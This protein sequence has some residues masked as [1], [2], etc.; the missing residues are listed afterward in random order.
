MARKRFDRLR[1][2]K[3]LTPALAAY[4]AWEDARGTRPRKPRAASSKPGGY[5]RRQVLPFG[6]EGVDLIRVRASERAINAIG[7]IIANRG[8]E[9]AA[10]AITLGNFNPAK[11][12]IFIG[13]G[14]ATS[15]ISEITRLSYE[16]KTGNS[17][18]APFGGQSATEKEFEAQQ[19]I[20]T[21]VF[22]TP[23]R[24]VS[25]TPERMYLYA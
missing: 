9:A 18:T 7:S 2:V 3:R 16:K 1:S 23:N 20:L 8:E 14:T 17:F 13:T 11:A 22:S 19:A 15:E 12:I 25:F 5:L 6:R 4:E 21:S 24:S 10:T